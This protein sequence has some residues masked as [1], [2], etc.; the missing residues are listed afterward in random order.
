MNEFLTDSIA[1]KVLMGTYKNHKELD[2]IVVDD[3]RTRIITLGF[4]CT[5][6]WGIKGYKNSEGIKKRNWY[7]RDP[8]YH[9]TAVE[10]H[11]NIDINKIQPILAQATTDLVGSEANMV[12]FGLYGSYFYRRNALLPEDL[13]VFILVEGAQNIAIDALRYRDSKLRDI[14]KNKSRVLPRSNEVGVSIVSID[15]LTPE[16]RS[17]IVIDCALVEISTTFSHGQTVDAIEL[18]PFVI[19]HNAQKI[20]NWGISSILHKP[21]SLLSRIDEAIRMRIML[22]EDHPEIDL[23]QFAIENSLPSKEEILLG[24]NDEHFLEMSRALINVLHEDEIRIRESIAR[25]FNVLG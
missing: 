12:G 5:P 4:D 3:V 19:V 2:K 17:Y 9:K 18:P 20:L 22:I 15:C 10:R 14:Y 8:H 24:M 1:T 25:S 7:F 13:D 16:N 21:F 6:N 23:D 11:N